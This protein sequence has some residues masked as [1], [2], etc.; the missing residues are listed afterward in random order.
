[1]GNVRGD[2]ERDVS[3]IDAN[4][5][6]LEPVLL[7]LLDPVLFLVDSTTL[8]LLDAVLALLELVLFLVDSA[9][10]NDKEAGCF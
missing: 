8:L 6:L 1:M 4:V 3:V 10:S 9:L 2:D 5:S 7:A